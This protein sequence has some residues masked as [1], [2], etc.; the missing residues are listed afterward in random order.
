MNVTGSL[1]I[2]PT[3]HAQT[4]L[5]LEYSPPAS[6]AR[7]RLWILLLFIAASLT[8]IVSITAAWAV[9]TIAPVAVSDANFDLFQNHLD[10]AQRLGILR[11]V[12]ETANVLALLVTLSNVCWTAL[13]LAVF[14]ILR[15]RASRSRS[16]DRSGFAG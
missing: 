7:T 8:G 11:A 14:L 9:A 12:Q 16:E 15:P 4:K 6:P 1:L 2:M 3:D 5:A 13:L 10:E